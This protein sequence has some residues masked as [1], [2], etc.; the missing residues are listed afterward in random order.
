MNIPEYYEDMS[1]RLMETLNSS[2]LSEHLRWQ[3]INTWLQI[4]NLDRIVLQ[5]HSGT[6]IKACYCGSQAEGTTTD[7]LLSDIDRVVYPKS[8]IVLE[9][10][11]SWEASLDTIE[12][13]LMVADESTPPGYVKLQLVQRDAP[14]LVN[15][16][17]NDHV[18]LDSK[19]HSVLGNTK[20]AR[21]IPHAN[22][23]HGPASR[24]IN[25]L[26]TADVVPG[27]HT[28]YWPYQ[29]SHWFPEAERLTGHQ[30]KSST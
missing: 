25:K 4:E 29:A 8:V 9:D 12:T 30:G 18:R 24:L 28:R 17:Q 21:T 5:S 14:I 22:E 1:L 27:L 2:G 10:L 3:R 23:Y 7:G 11:Q 20:V 6:D 19:H 26:F 13:F 15:N 16:Y